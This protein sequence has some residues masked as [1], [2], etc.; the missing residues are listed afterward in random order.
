MRQLSITNWTSATPSSLS[1][2]FQEKK[3]ALEVHVRFSV[4]SL[5]RLIR[6]LRQVKVASPDESGRIVTHEN[7]PDFSNG[8]YER[9]S[10]KFADENAKC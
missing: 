6:T 9:R 4:N 1:G 8:N 5:T 7:V 3:D 10:S 2:C